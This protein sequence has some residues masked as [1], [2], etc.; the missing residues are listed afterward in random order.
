[1]VVARKPWRANSDSAAFR[2]LRVEASDLSA[3]VR[4]FAI[5]PPAERRQ[6]QNGCLRNERSVFK[7][8]GR[9][10]R[11]V[12]GGGWPGGPPESTPLSPLHR[13]PPDRERGTLL[14]RSNQ[15]AIAPGA[16]RTSATIGR[17]Q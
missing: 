7:M 10:A 8:V 2:T 11:A 15:R 17:C 12:K 6:I 5:G 14:R 16:P 4:R 1:M 13:T 3:W 9:A